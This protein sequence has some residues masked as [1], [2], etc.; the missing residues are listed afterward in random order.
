M[1]ALVA[2]DG[3]MLLGDEGLKILV[4]ECNKKMRANWERADRFFA[5]FKE[6]FCSGMDRK[7]TG[8]RDTS[9][10]ET[11][12]S[13][14]NDNTNISRTTKKAAKECWFLVDSLCAKTCKDAI[15]AKKRVARPKSKISV[16]FHRRGEKETFGR[17]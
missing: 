10:A 1:E 14:N 15:E 12:S 2:K 17:R 3:E 7:N 5:L 13:G 6:R 4:E 8:V 16:R 9:T 11:T